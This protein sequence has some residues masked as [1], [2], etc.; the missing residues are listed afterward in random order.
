MAEPE[1]APREL[2][3]VHVVATDAAG[4]LGQYLIGA[5]AHLPTPSSVRKAFR[6]RE[7]WVEGALASGRQ[8]ALAGSRVELLRPRRHPTRPFVHPMSVLFDDD[9]LAV[10]EKPAGLMVMGNRFRTVEN[11]LP[12]CLAPSVVDGALAWPR[13][14]H[15]LDVRTGGALV[16]AK[17]AGALRALSL[18][19]AQ[20]EV[21]KQYRA[22]VVGRLEGEGEAVSEVD[23]R[24]AHT[25]WRA[26]RC[27]RSL[28]AGWHTEVELHPTT[29]RTHQLRR[30]LA[31]LGH[32]VVG[33][34]LYGAG[35]PILKGAGLFLWAE[36][37]EL[38]HPVS[39]SPLAVEAPVPAKF[40]RFVEREDRRAERVAQAPTA[41]LTSS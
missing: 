33:D 7:V 38:A 29:G 17:T 1:A 24:A 6:R 20:R 26:L 14:V 34:D 15:R 40:A 11:A 18:A 8:P 16:V 39:G 3:E 41:D 28:I 35:L 12:H 13:P 37:V 23:G 25:R 30:H 36:R 21:A 19:F 32:P 4:E 22:V 5:M 9:H 31:E 2:V 10:V 27:G